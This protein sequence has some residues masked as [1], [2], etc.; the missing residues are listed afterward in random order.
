M[1]LNNAAARRGQ[2]V[3]YEVGTSGPQNGER[4]DTH[5]LSS[6]TQLF[7]SSDITW[8]AIVKRRLAFDYYQFL[9]DFFV[10]SV[11]GIEYGR[12]SAKR[13]DDAKE[14]AAAQALNTIA[15]GY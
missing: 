13:Q 10:V 6:D 7:I 15:Q 4:T 9:S 3:A 5:C 11:N 8:T 1:Q 2:T 14:G 12:A